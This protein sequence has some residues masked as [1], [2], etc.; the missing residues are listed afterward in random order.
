MNESFSD[1]SV[2]GGIWEEECLRNFYDIETYNKRGYV[3]ASVLGGGTC[4]SEFEFLTGC[5]MANIKPGIYPY[6]A[7]NL[8]HSDSLVR[9]F[10]ENGYQTIAFHPYIAHNWNRDRIYKELGFDVFLSSDDMEYTDYISWGV[11]DQCNYDY[12]KKL[13]EE[14]KGPLF[15]FNVTMQNHG[16]YEDI[17]LKEG[18]EYVSVDKKYSKYEDLVTYLTL[19]RESDRAFKDFIEYFSK[20]EE[21]VLICIFG[22]H[23]PFLN[24]TLLKELNIG[25]TIDEQEKRY[26]IPFMIWSNFDTEISGQKCDMGINYLGAH[27]LEILNMKSDYAEYLLHLQKQ[28]PVMNA[29]GYQTKD[30]IWHDYS[31]ENKLL[32]EYKCIAYYQLFDRYSN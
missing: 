20:A 7:Y 4:N 5:S 3:Y 15:L 9:L 6:Q 14:K 18:T 23:Q 12:I 2:A 11:S 13:Y 21:P 29:V 19:M 24:D 16:G 30:G 8:N 32:D 22:D 27:L 25:S 26:M 10:H 17:Q 31:E 1:L 28:I